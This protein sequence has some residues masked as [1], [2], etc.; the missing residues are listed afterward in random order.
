M[1]VRNIHDYFC[2]FSTVPAGSYVPRHH[3][4]VFAELAYI[5]MPA[6]LQLG[7]WGHQNAVHVFVY[8]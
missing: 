4:A 2:R 7:V 6:V 5:A 1:F 8:V 3:I